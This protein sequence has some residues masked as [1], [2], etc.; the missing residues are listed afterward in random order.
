MIF[1]SSFLKKDTFYHDFTP[2]SPAEMMCI[3]I[4]PGTV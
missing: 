2:S 1:G 3:D 4:I